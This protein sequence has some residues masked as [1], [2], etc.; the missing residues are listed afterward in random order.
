VRTRWQA[1]GGVGRHLEER[2][3]ALGNL[4]LHRVQLQRRAR[5]PLTPT[6]NILAQSRVATARHVAQ[7]AV[8]AAESSKVRKELGLVPC[9]HDRHARVRTTVRHEP[10]SAALTGVVGDHQPGRKSHLPLAVERFNKL[11]C[12]RARGG[13]HVQH[14]VVWAHIK[15]DSRQHRRRL[16]AHQVSSIAERD[17]PSMEAMVFGGLA[18]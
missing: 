8:E 16:L 12:L 13:T 2:Q 5:R 7:D 1:K 9:R 15:E 10:P 3:C 17:Q 4:Q 6:V 14:H 18:Q 11:R